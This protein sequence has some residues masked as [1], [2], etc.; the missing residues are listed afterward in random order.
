MINFIINNLWFIIPAYLTTLLLFFGVL[1]VKILTKHIRYL[2]PLLTPIDLGINF[3]DKKPI[4]GEGKPVVGWIM[5][6]IAAI[7]SYFLIGN[8]FHMLLISFSSFFGDLAGS[9]LKRRV[10]V[11]E[12]KPLIVVDQISFIFA[13][14]VGAIT[15]GFKLPINEFLW[16]ILLTFGIHFFVNLILFK[17]KLKSKPY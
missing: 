2:N 10:G 5:P 16:I 11:A 14:Y 13:A 1:L 6:L 17:L 12:H 9:F 3:F 15:F 4:I 7:G 8:F